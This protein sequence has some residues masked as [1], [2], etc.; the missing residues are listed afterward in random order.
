MTRTLCAALLALGLAPAAGAQVLPAS[1]GK[2]GSLP[3]QEQYKLRGEYRWYSP[4]YDGWLAKGDLGDEVGL[5]DDLNTQ[6]DSSWQA[7]GTLQ[8]KPGIKLRG[9]YLKVETSGS[10]TGAERAADP[11]ARTVIYGGT[12]FYKD[13][14]LGGSVKGAYYSG[15]FEYDVMKGPKGYLGFMGGARVLDVDTVV[16]STSLNQR[17]A[18]TTMSVIPTLGAIL[19]IYSG[20]FSVEGEAAGMSLSD[21]EKVYDV[22][23]SARFHIADRVAAMGG[24]RALSHTGKDGD[25]RVKLKESG[26]QFGVEISL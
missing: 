6:D 8:F 20:K 11:T 10:V 3:K 25:R 24:Y 22:G 13:L 12:R 26:W 21:D 18:D 5:K 4:A 19:R 23:V 17:H 14:D 7:D 15:D 16:V 9:S 1:S 2:T